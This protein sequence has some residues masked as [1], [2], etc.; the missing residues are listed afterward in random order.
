[1]VALI[2][3]GVV[4]IL[5]GWLIFLPWVIEIDTSRNTYQVYQKGT[6]RFWLTTGFQPH[7]SFFGISVPMKPGEKKSP[8]KQRAK[9]KKKKRQFHIQNLWDLWNGI[10]HSIKV[11]WF[12]LDM[13]TDDVVLNAQLIPAFSYLSRGP[14]HLTT[15]FEGRVFSRLRIELKMYRMGWAFLLFFIKNKKYGNEF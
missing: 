7:M 12:Y 5:F 15:N 4:L 2:I 9:S 6:V 10:V 3:A 8:V 11:K 13:D 1:M 14:M